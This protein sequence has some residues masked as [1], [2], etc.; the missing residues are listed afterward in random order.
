MCLTILLLFDL[1]AGVLGAADRK[2]YCV[3]TI[4]IIDILS[5]IPIIS[6]VS[7]DLKVLSFLR[8]FKAMRVLKLRRL[9]EIRREH[10]LTQQIF[11]LLT[12]LLGLIII[13]A[14][15]MFEISH[16]WP[17]AFTEELK[18]HDALYFV[19]VTFTTIGYGD[20]TANKASTRIIMTISI[21]FMISI[22]PLQ[23]SSVVDAITEL[24][25]YK[26]YLRR[27]S[28]DHVVIIWYEPAEYEISMV[29]RELF[30]SYKDKKLQ[31]AL[32]GD[33]DPSDKLISLLKKPKYELVQ[34]FKGDILRSSILKKAR[35][36]K[37]IIIIL[38]FIVV[39]YLYLYNSIKKQKV[40]F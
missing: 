37:Y 33:K 38:Y 36:Y 29:L 22:L 16:I 11:I 3:S 32:I 26:S 6:L 7:D 8:I 18:F 21:G 19:I 5:I 23:L 4:F 13:C 17:D 1:V 35:V 30:N 39:I 15:I 20:I 9:V 25:K 28:K 14:S 10:Q 12:I 27:I 24:P 2:T 31:V 40:V 34:Y